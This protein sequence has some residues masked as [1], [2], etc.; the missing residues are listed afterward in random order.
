MAAYNVSLLYSCSKGQN[1]AIYRQKER[2]KWPV[3]AEKIW[4]SSSNYG[5]SARSAKINSRK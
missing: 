5:G 4:I 3:P 1:Y 2:K